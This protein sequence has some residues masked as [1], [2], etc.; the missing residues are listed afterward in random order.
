[1][2][3]IKMDDQLG[4]KQLLKSNIK[5]LFEEKI[6]KLTTILNLLSLYQSN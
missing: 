4:I 5:F 2:I 6:K 3:K 1:M